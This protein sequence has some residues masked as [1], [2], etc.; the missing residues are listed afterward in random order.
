MIK[1]IV[2]LFFEPD[3]EI[4]YE[5]TDLSFPAMPAR[6]D[7]IWLDVPT[8]NKEEKMVVGVVGDITWQQDDDGVMEPTIFCYYDPSDP[9]ASA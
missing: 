9:D 8:K 2:T 6:G 7:E 5:Y 3:R 1:A 4:C